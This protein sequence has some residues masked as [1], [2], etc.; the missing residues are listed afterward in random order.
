MRKAIPLAVCVLLL[1]AGCGGLD[2]QLPGDSEP[3]PTEPEPT[4]TDSAAPDISTDGT[5]TPV[6]GTE[7][8]AT[9]EPTPTPGDDD[10]LSR[11][12]E[13]EHGTDPTVADTD[14]DGLSDGAEVDEYGTDP[15]VAD[16]DEDGLS[17]GAEV[18][19]HGTDPTVAD[20][21]GDG[22]SDSEELSEYGT[23]PTAADTDGDGLTDAE[24]VSEYETDPTTADTDGDSLP[25]GAEAEMAD[26]YP[27]A[28]P[29]RKDIFVEVDYTERVS[30]R[31]IRDLEREFATAPVSNP[32]GSNGIQLHVYFDDELTC[33]EPLTRGYPIEYVC[34]ADGYTTGDLDQQDENPEVVRGSDFPGYYDIRIVGQVSRSSGRQMPVDGVAYGGESPPLAFVEEQTDDEVTTDIFLHELG[35][36]LGIGGRFPGV[37][38]RRYSFAEYPS[39]MNYNANSGFHEFAT[40]TPGSR[41][42]WEIINA[43]LADR[44]DSRAILDAENDRD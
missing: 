2:S 43:S 20:T 3:E 32:D 37:D 38:S 9:P 41:T 33:S 36:L 30:D 19:E 13:R 29:L 26:L 28:D 16:T 42:D 6:D 25:D 34:A 5:D 4:S 14:G 27:D 7:T 31:Q 18:T 39:V 22:F 12:E 40:T 17:D 21:D 23:D 44:F 15:T 1:L 10:G 24:E 8:T 35:H 11:V